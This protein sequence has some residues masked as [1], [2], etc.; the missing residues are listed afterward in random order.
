[1]VPVAWV[2]LPGLPVTSNGKLDRRALP[3]PEP[4]ETADSMALE[5]P[6]EVALARLWEEV[7]NAGAVGAGDH[8]FELGGHSLLAT[9]LLSR[10]QAEFSVQMPLR[11]LFIFPTLAGMA[12]RIEDLVLAG[13][14]EQDVDKLLDLL[15]SLD[16]DAAAERL[17]LAR[18]LSGDLDGGTL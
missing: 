14:D 5:T 18:S 7:L 2:F 12:A 9:Q 8:F 11:E 3:Q 10:I 13:S 4:S 1:M 15:E 16:E 17:H 6:T